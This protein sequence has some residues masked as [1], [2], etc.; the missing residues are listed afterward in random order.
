MENGNDERF[1]ISK[2]KYEMLKEEEEQIELCT[3][4]GT[5]GFDYVT[6]FNKVNK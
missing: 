5:F 6:E 3:V 2:T 4:K 1:S